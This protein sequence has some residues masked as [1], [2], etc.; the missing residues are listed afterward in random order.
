MS[1]PRVLG[2]LAPFLSDVFDVVTFKWAGAGDAVS[3]EVEAI[4]T[5]RCYFPFPNSL[6]ISAQPPSASPVLT[7]IS[8]PP[9]P[10]ISWF[11]APRP[12]TPPMEATWWWSGLPVHWQ[13]W[14]LH[15][16]TAT[17]AT[18]TIC[19]T[20]TVTGLTPPALQ[21]AHF[22]SSPS[23]TLTLLPSRSTHFLKRTASQ[24]VRWRTAW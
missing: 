5:V 15:P 17:T 18:T 13:T 19:T 20:S 10:R 22:P 7:L 11:I 12:A 1:I 24:R 3:V 16:T 14:Y 4:L 21:L 2:V 6:H 23:P 9:N 8:E